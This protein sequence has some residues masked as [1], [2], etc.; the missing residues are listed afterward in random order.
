VL[1]LLKNKF[2][3]IGAGVLIV[4]LIAGGVFFFGQGEAPPPVDNTK[5]ELIWWKLDQDDR[6]YDDIIDNFFAETGIQNAEI[7]VVNPEFESE[8]EYYRNLLTALAQGTGP[9]IFTIRHD[10]FAAWREFMT[11]ISNVF[12]F[13]D[14]EIFANYNTNFID[15]VKKDTTYRDQIYGVTSYVDNLQLYYNEDILEQGNISTPPDTW[16]RLIRD[17]NSLNS[18]NLRGEFEQS[19]ISLGTGL[20][21]KDGDVSEDINI[22]HFQD[23]LPLLIFQNGGQL[24]DYTEERDIFGD[25]DP[26][27]TLR[28]EELTSDNPALSALE[29][30]LSFA[31]PVSNR[32]SWSTDSEKNTEQFLE[33]KLAYIINY[34]S[35]DSEIQER[36]NRLNYS[37]APLPQLDPDNR[38]TYGKFYLDGINRQLELDTEQNPRDPVASKKLSVAR[39][40]MYYLSTAEAQELFAVETG[41]PSAHRE[42]LE[43]QLAGD[44]RLRVFASGALVADN[45]YKPDPNRVDKMWGDLIYRVQFENNTAQ[46]SL[47]KA[48]QEYGIMVQSG[49]QLRFD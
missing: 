43:S 39:G 27:D 26:N 30:Y 14:S 18:R 3:L 35:F 31:S 22:A 10:D 38:K 28:N 29:F 47:S 42:V 7:T 25:D 36:N 4:V 6:T 21:K 16:D 17:I 48:I 12:Q 37:V 23:I 45:Y 41:L 1:S 11:P 20:L 44:E 49:P 33:G 9:D 46:E 13:S 32:Y 19:T 5:V 40:F 15:L 34:R 24:Y 2:V 8:E